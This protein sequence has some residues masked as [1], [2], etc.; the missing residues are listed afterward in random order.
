MQ[1]FQKFYKSKD[2]CTL[3][4]ASVFLIDMISIIMLVW[5]E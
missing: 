4:A 1:R 2:G 5:H 3:A